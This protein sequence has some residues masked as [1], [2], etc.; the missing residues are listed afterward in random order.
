M[1]TADQVADD[2]DQNRMEVLALT[3]TTLP[4]GVVYLLVSMVAVCSGKLEGAENLLRNPGFEE[5]LH[6]AWEKRTPE[7]ASR[8]LGRVAGVGRSGDWAAA[9]ENLRPAYTRLRQGHQRSI[10][11]EPGS[12]I[13]LGAWVKSDLSDEGI[14]TL[15]LYCMGEEDEIR[16][17][18]TSGPVRGRCDWT[19]VRV[20]AL[21]PDGTAYVMAYLQIREGVGRVLFDDVELAVRRQPRPREPAPKVGLLTDLAEGSPCLENLKILFAE[22]LVRLTPEKAGEQ[23]ADCAS[24][25]VL[26]GSEEVP[27][28][29][30][31][32]VERFASRGGPVFMDIRN[33]AQWQAVQTARV[34]VKPEGGGSP[35]AEMTAGL[36]VVKASETTA[37]F[38]VGQIIPRAS[39]P[40]GELLVLPEEVSKPGLEVLAVGPGGEPGLVRLPIGESFVAAAD[41]LS[42]REPYC[43][44]VDAYYK[45]TLITNTLTNPVQFGEY[46]PK[47]LSYA[48]F[49]GVAKETAA[50]YPAVNFQE[51]G[52]ASDDYRIF[53][54]RLGR[55]GAPLYFLYAAAHGSEWEPGYGLLTFAKRVAEGR[56]NDVVDLDEVEIKIVP[57]LNPWGYDN[58]RRH[59]A[60]GV[61][62]NR[63]GDYRWEQF[64]GRNSNKD[65]AWSPGDYDWKGTSPFSEPE[66]R[67][68]KAIIDRAANLYCVLDYHGNSSASSNKVG[69][70]PVCAQPDNQLCAMDLQQIANRRLAGRHILRQNDEETFSQYLLT[71]VRMGGGIPFLINTSAR[72]RFGLLIELTAGYPESYGT[73]LQTDVTCE[74]CRAL[75]V[76]YPPPEKWPE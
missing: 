32:A 53:S 5:A 11:V 9:L 52:P 45:Y 25:L 76:A 47:K 61:D 68:Y 21:V 46:Y 72:E 58:R 23:L 49:V 28:S 37:G 3:F 40:Q 69:I 51:E 20:G 12:L 26:F 65:G 59:N 17:Q 57:V 48:E 33:F 19:N 1:V 27:E 56:M 16:V 22:G 71:R 66:S 64:Q 14:L 6:P 70:L 4:R 13:E 55:P 18:P 67:T 30:L 39:H 75:F 29:A 35:Q 34:S 41:V 43:R 63:Q 24:A 2:P 36:R 60:G 50:S 62:L 73:V 54:L 74:L 38:E 8:K 44:N 15:Q 10:V 42:L 7:D 31:D